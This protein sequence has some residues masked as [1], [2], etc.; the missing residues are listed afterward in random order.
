MQSERA[1]CSISVELWDNKNK[2]RKKR[3]ARN[4]TIRILT[5]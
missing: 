1:E 2:I 3:A 4:G 5:N